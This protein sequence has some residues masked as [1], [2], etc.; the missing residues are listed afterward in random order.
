MKND[1]RIYTL[2]MYNSE[3]FMVYARV[4]CYING[5]LKLEF[6]EGCVMI[7]QKIN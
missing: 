4:L 3:K 6:A 2:D 7:I 5:V 1:N